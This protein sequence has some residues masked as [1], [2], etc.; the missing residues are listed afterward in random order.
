MRM[1]WVSASAQPGAML[2][3][4]AARQIALPGGD[5]AGE[6]T[7]DRGPARTCR[8]DD[9]GGRPAADARGTDRTA[10]RRDPAEW[11]RRGAA[12]ADGVAGHA[13]G[14]AGDRAGGGHSSG[15]GARGGRSDPAAPAARE[16]EGDGPKAP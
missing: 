5:D 3:S 9:R 1:R 4:L 13:G 14:R 7:T 2:E 8:G 12:G 6:G 11:A 16:P 15:A 10:E